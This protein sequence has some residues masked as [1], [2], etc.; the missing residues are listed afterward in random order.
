VPSRV[1]RSSDQ[2]SRRSNRCFAASV[3]HLLE[4]G[5][6]AVLSRNFVSVF[7]DHSPALPGG[8]LP[9]LQELI[10]RVLTLVVGRDA[11]V[12]RD[13]YRASPFGYCRYSKRPFYK[14]QFCGLARC[15]GLVDHVPRVRNVF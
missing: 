10:E 2:K 11:G 9:E 15:A 3:K 5:P 14:R 8:E 4:T 12:D 6:F 1:S 13:F 7:R